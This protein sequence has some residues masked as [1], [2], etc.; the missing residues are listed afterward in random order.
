MSQPR[1]RAVPGKWKREGLLLEPTHFLPIYTSLSFY[2][3]V[4]L[5]SLSQ[6]MTASHFVTSLLLSTSLLLQRFL[7][8]R[9][10]R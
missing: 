2:A 1:Y 7:P 3:C 10:I 9:T 8:Q 4:Q 5:T 6:S